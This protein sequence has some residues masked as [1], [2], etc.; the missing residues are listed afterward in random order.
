MSAIAFDSASPPSQKPR[1]SGVTMTLPLIALAVGAFGIGTTEFVVMGLLPEL[2]R[3]LD[4]AIADAGLV[5]TAYAAGVV[6]G[7]PVMAVATNGLPRKASL[8][9]LMAIFV[10]GN[11]LC[12]IAPDY[13]LLILARIVTAFCHGA[14]FGIAAVV[15]ADIALPGK[16]AQA[17]ALVFAGLT[18]ANIMGVPGGTTIGHALG[19]RATFWTVVGVGIVSMIAIAAWLPTGLKSPKGDLVREFRVL[20][21]P[22]VFLAMSMTVLT[23]AS[24]FVVFTFIAPLLATVTSLTTSGV[25]SALLVFGVGMTVGSFVGGRLADWRLMPAIAGTIVALMAVLIMILLLSESAVAMSVIMFVWGLVIFSLAPPLQIR[26]VNAAA[27][28]PN[29]ASTLNQAAFNLGNAG[30]A[31]LGS[32]LLALGF[33]YADLAWAGIGLAW[34][35][36]L[37]AFVSRRMDSRGAVASS[38]MTPAPVA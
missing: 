11:A 31:W 4:V 19:W 20:A 25:T 24:L 28:A 1:P 36:L 26:V 30:G 27:D 12:A 21:R 16:R 29:V 23:S 18:V 9:T 32:M 3:D 13:T 6:V 15:A 14:F 35:A 10:L 38:A 22:R 8:L 34:F 17:V 5:V 2:A 33:G 37:A 7:A